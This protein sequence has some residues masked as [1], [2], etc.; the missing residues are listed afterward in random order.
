MDEESTPWIVDAKFWRD[1]F[2]NV[3]A[4]LIVA[5]I[6][7]VIAVYGGYIAAPDRVV[8]L[9]LTGLLVL[10]ILILLSLV[11]SNQKNEYASPQEIKR[12][13]WVAARVTLFSLVPVVLLLIDSFT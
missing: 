13:Y 2:S 12:G 7:W 8:P 3:F 1:V 9:T 5:G 11:R 6:L 4:G 10:L